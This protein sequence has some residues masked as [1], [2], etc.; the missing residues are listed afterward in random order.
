VVRENLTGKMGTFEARFTVPD[1]SADTSGLK[2]SSIIWSNQRQPVQTAVGTAEKITNKEAAANPLIVENQKI[3]PNIT[4][5]FRRDQNLYV[6]FDVYDSL[7]DPAAPKG[8]RI[9]VSMSLFTSKGAKAFEI[10]PIAASQLINT[11]PEAVPVQVQV[12][13]KELVPGRYTCQINVVDE[14]GRKFAFR[15]VPFV[16]I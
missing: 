10:G 3:V 15:R 16:V 5:V 8:R 6:S 11:R 13:L 14:S 9:K 12:P 7:P 1:L 4:H 2:L